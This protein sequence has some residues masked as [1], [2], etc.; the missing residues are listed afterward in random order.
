M[1]RAWGEASECTW[2]ALQAA[3]KRDA[4]SSAELAYTA[5]PACTCTPEQLRQSIV[6][7]PYGLI[8]HM[9]HLTNYLKQYGIYKGQSVHGT[10]RGSML[11]HKEVHQATHDGIRRV[12]PV[13]M[14]AAS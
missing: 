11:H 10:R 7:D 9:A 1:Q 6:R 14:A 5:R 12:L 13:M 4:L 3:H 8:S 2:P